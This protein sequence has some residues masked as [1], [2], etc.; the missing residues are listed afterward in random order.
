MN[1]P[2]IQFT[3]I[4]SELHNNVYNFH[5][6]VPAALAAPFIDDQGDRRVVA[7]LNGEHTYQC[8]LMPKGDGDFFIMLNKK[9]REK[10]GLFTGV[11][12]D[13]VL[14]KDTSEYGLPMPA[15]FAELLTID[16]AGDRYFHALTPGK[17]RTMIHWIGSVKNPDLQLRRALIVVEHLKN[18]QGK[19]DFK[20]LNAEVKNSRNDF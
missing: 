2:T 3:S 8:A 10:L 13:V 18:N 12:V 11:P 1:Q 9:T 14:L 7:T 5:L 16:E 19:I 15:E 6:P 20:L 4:V 17:Q